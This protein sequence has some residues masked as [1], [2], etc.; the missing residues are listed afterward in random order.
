[1]NSP[2]LTGFVGRNILH[3]VALFVWLSR[4]VAGWSVVS[5]VILLVSSLVRRK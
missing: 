1:M 2:K 5:L 4:W 3:V